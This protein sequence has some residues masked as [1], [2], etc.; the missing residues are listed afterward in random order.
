MRAQ[1]GSETARNDTMLVMTGGGGHGRAGALNFGR[2]GNMNVRALQ[3]RFY[4]HHLKDADN[5]FDREPRVQMFVQVPP[6]S[7]TEGSG[8][9]VT[10]ETFPLAGTET[11]RFN[12]RSGGHANTRWGD[13]VLDASEPSDGPDDAF[14]YDP[15]DPVP[16]LGGGLCCLTLGF[17]F[18]AGVQDQSTLELRDDVLVYTSAPL[19]EDMAVLGPV[20]VT[21]WASSS[22]RDTDFT[23]KLVDVHPDGFAQNALNR[24]VRARFRHGSRA[25]PSLIEPG[26][27][28]EY[29]ID[30][31]YTGN[32]FSGRTPG[33]AR[34]LLIE[35]PPP[36]PQP[37]HGE[38][39]RDRRPDR[40]RGADDPSQPDPPGVRGA[41]G[42]PGR[43]DLTTPAVSKDNAT[44]VPARELHS[45]RSARSSSPRGTHTRT[46]GRRLASTGR[47]PSRVPYTCPDRRRG[48]N[49]SGSSLE[50]RL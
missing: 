24:V 46:G 23:V 18:R 1:A 10:G 26:K 38:Q 2:A 43:H 8:F 49:T 6:D 30:L 7:G 34:H 17:Y 44:V 27:P 31:G 42:S 12:L 13:G 37:E 28:Y 16:S 50:L 22:A 35:V 47:Q 29:E 21:F 20:T 15:N 9:W 33:Q 41:V 40:D 25:A 32:V 3:L 5:G 48:V 4:D 45:A 19:T 36:G 14:V 11:V 39:P